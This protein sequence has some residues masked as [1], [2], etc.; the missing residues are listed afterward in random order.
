PTRRSSDLSLLF[1]SS[2]TPPLYFLELLLLFLL[3][4]S[5]FLPIAWKVLHF[6]IYH[7]SLPS[8]AIPYLGY[9]YD[10]IHHTSLLL[11]L[12]DESEWLPNVSLFPLFPT[13]LH[14]LHNLAS[15]HFV[16]AYDIQCLLQD[17]CN[18]NEFQFL[19]IEVLFHA[20]L[21]SLH[22]I[23]SLASRHFVH[24]YGRKLPMFFLLVSFLMLQL[25]YYMRLMFH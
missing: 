5:Q 17:Y 15:L 12:S 13:F 24:A 20:F 6:L 8:Q 19:L 23:Q 7:H 14:L 21:M 11:L 10:N 3:S 22:W 25:L 4:E 2:D 1:D 18:P 9:A 16:H